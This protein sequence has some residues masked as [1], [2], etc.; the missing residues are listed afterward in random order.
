[1]T[2]RSGVGKEFPTSTSSFTH[3]GHVTLLVFLDTLD[4]NERRVTNLLYK[5]VENTSKATRI[6]SKFLPLLIVFSYG[7]GLTGV[8]RRDKGREKDLLY[9]FLMDAERCVFY[10]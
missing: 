5:S 8:P 1:M 3:I 6:D 7:A 4:K 2:P 9:K 10:V